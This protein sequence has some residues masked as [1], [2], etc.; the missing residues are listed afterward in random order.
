LNLE[1]RLPLRQH[2]ALQQNHLLVGKV[3][4]L[5]L[6]LD[7]LY[8]ANQPSDLLLEGPLLVSQGGQLRVG[9][10]VLGTGLAEVER[11]GEREESEQSQ[12]EGEEGRAAHFELWGIKI[13][14]FDYF[15]INPG[16]TVRFW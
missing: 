1:N 11:E 16:C 8:V 15:G 2:R 13:I 14:W 3:S 9:G 5:H 10:E 4:C 12:E 6:G 7:V